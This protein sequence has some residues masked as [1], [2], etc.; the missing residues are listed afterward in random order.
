MNYFAFFLGETGYI[1]KCLMLLKYV[2]NPHSKSAPHIT[3][4]LFKD[5]VSKLDYLRSTKITYLNIVEPGT[6][7]FEN[8][9]R[10]AVVFL[11]CE[12]EELEELDYRPD[13]PFSRLHIT[14]YE[15]YNREYAKHLFQKLKK[16][17]WNVRLSFDS[18][19]KLKEKKLGTRIGSLNNYSRLYQEIIGQ[20]LPSDDVLQKEINDNSYVYADRI[21][22]KLK[23]YLDK[24]PTIERF[25]PVLD[26][27]H[28]ALSEYDKYFIS[29]S[30]KHNK[31]V[32]DAIYVT[33]PEYSK[34]MAICA[35]DAIKGTTTINF[36]DSS[37]GTGSLFL[38]LYRLIAEHNID[39]TNSNNISIKSAIGIDID[40]EMASDASMRFWQR[41]LI[42]YLDDAITSSNFSDS[43]RNLMMVNPPYNKSNEIPGNY[44]KVIS[45]LAK[46]ATGIDVSAKAGLYVY[47]MLI[48][49]KW[50]AKNGIGVWLIPTVF[51]QADYA[52][53]LRKYL[54]NN[55]QLLRLHVY[56][57]EQRQFENAMV[58]TTIVVFKKCT[59]SKNAIV[60]VSHGENLGDNSVPRGIPFSKFIENID[61][62]RALVFA[63]K[64]KQVP[65]NE[66]NI[67]FSELFDA[68]RGIATGANK[69]FVLE[70]NKAKELGIPDCALKP[71]LPKARFINSN[72]IQS[73]P[74]GYPDVSPKL[75]LIDCDLDEITIKQKYPLFYDYLQKAKQKDDNGRRIID[76]T[77]VKARSPWYKQESRNAPMFFLT[78]MGRPKSNLPTLY[79]LFNKSKAIALNT[80]IMVYPKPWLFDLLCNNDELCMH[81]L[82]CLN[83]VGSYDLL[84]NSRVYSG[85]LMKLEPGTLKKIKLSNLPKQII[86]AYKTL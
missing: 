35:L 42:I 31:P 18:P 65:S 85:G 69:Y 20:T 6:F 22:E 16:I 36:G 28:S 71:V 33:P 45:N 81:L 59:P 63:Q 53:A 51:L 15:G 24:T 19:E 5:S 86:D 34:D 67:P 4:R 1:E 60:E 55:V 54:T 80:Y 11:K 75:A 32:K 62:W 84:Q 72:T 44:K 43:S 79:F 9:N 57:E 49:D 37:I 74:D 26:K 14:L 50:L 38:A 61:N 25:N 66:Q 58:A 78:Y 3:V 13:F 77:L 2:G 52:I 56:N 82:E 83:D 41:G 46:K 68:K 76:R 8:A 70:F 12:S 27:K 39:N 73:L 40:Q 64:N 23:S 47:H 7:N 48:M 29:N 30:T 17:N 21:L 10:K